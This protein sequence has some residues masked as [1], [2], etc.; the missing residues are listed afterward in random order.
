[1]ASVPRVDAAD[2]PSAI[3]A[4]EKSGVVILS[5]FTTPDIVDRANADLKEHLK[6]VLEVS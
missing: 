4:L 5:N 3:D 2:I 1:M 6:V